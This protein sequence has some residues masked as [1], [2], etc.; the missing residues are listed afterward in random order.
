VAGRIGKIGS[1][2]QLGDVADDTGEC[3]AVIA[4]LANE[5]TGR[6]S[7]AAAGLGV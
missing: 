6:S 3:F 1:T 7:S 4:Y 2:P 5:L